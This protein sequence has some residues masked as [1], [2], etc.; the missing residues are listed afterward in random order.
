VFR[1]LIMPLLFTELGIPIGFQLIGVSYRYLRVLVLYLERPR[2]KSWELRRC[3]GAL[4]IQRLEGSRPGDYGIYIRLSSLDGFLV[5]R[6]RE[7]AWLSVAGGRE[8]GRGAVDRKVWSA[9]PYC[10]LR[11]ARHRSG[12]RAEARERFEAGDVD[13]CRA[14]AG[15][16]RRGRGDPVGD[17]QEHHLPWSG[18]PATSTSAG[19]T[20]AEQFSR[21]GLACYLRGAAFGHAF[22]DRRYTLAN[23][24]YIHK[25]SSR[26]FDLFLPRHEGN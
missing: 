9:Q 23:V 7:R 17:P 3:A 13:S 12:V 24:R 6:C 8:N 26:P 2:A 19:Q 10:V 1:R 16:R 15:M 5:Y 20:S 4:Q 14:P 18:T 22:R 11:N 25:L 21:R